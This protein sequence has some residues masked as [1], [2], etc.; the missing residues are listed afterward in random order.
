VGDDRLRNEFD[1]LS[2]AEIAVSIHAPKEKP[3]TSAG[4]VREER[5]V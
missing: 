2:Q 3:G 5:E 4:R 1:A